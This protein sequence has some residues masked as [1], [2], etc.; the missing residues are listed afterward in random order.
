MR[1]LKDA[2]GIRGR[3]SLYYL[4]I[5]GAHAGGQAWDFGGVGSGTAPGVFMHE[6]GHT[7]N[8]PHWDKKN[9]PYRGDMYGIKSSKENA[10]H[11]GPTWAYDLPNKYFI[12]CTIQENCVESRNKRKKIP[13]TFKQDPMAGGGTG[14][15]EEGY[16]YRHF[17]DFS[18]TKIQQYYEDKMVVWNEELKSY[19]T[20]NDQEGAYTNLLSNNGVEYPVEREVEVIS[21]M[22]STCEKYPQATLV[23][24]P[25]GTYSSGIIKTFDPTVE[26]DRKE[27]KEIFCPDGGC[28]L[29]L[30]VTQGGKTSTYMLRA[31]I[32][33]G[34]SSNKPKKLHLQKTRAVNLRASDGEVT[35]IELLNTPDA[36]VNG[37]PDNPTVLD[38]W[39]K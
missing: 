8:L 7:F 28:D 4:N 3:Y 37:L 26:E 5:Y 25:I 6:C 9:Y 14:D 18:M 32:D 31:S 35:K 2:N 27:A 22:A 21:V 23:Y 20:W 34:N 17:S 12:P 33:D 36:E 30:R 19:A 29:S 10:I 39:N 1:A 15:Q 38:T 16:I 24:P 11:A 13:G